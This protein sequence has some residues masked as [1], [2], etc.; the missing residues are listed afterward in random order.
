MGLSN[1]QHAFLQ[2]SIVVVTRKPSNDEYKDQ[3]R[4]LFPPNLQGAQKLARG[5][6]LSPYKGNVVSHV[7]MKI[8]GFGMRIFRAL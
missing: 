7:E 3:S 5:F 4:S 1:K 8:E 6:T 2:E